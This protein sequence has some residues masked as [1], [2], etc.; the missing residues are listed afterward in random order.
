MGGFDHGG[1]VSFLFRDQDSWR[2][3]LIMTRSIEM[4]KKIMIVE[5]NVAA[6][7]MIRASLEAFGYNVLDLVMQGEEIVQQIEE[8]KPDLIIMDIVLQRGRMDG[9]TAAE[10][11]SES[12]DTPIVYITGNNTDALYARA[13]NTRPYGYILKPFKPAELRAAV[14]MALNKSEAESELKKH[15]DQLEELVSERTLEL[16][17]MNE[18]LKASLREKEILLKEIHHRVKNNMQLISSLLHIQAAHSED[19]K[20]LRFYEESRNRIRAMALVHESLYRSKSLAHIDICEHTRT[21]VSQL[22]RS[23]ECYDVE[24]SITGESIFLGIDVAI[25]F[26]LIVNE[27]VSNAFRHGLRGREKG[28]LGVEVHCSPE[29]VVTLIVSDNGCG[30]PEG[31]D[32][33]AS[34]S[35]GLQLVNDLVG[36]ID[37]SIELDGSNGTT[38]TVRFPVPGSISSR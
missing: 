35:L 12:F 37:G 5:D 17:S 9:I 33:R 2:R 26:G 1:G 30:F 11:I 34:S 14:E 18:Q 20:F 23:Y 8:K 15:R 24:L 4:S 19:P 10:K 29:R 13:R 3:A 28:A 7:A 32:F 22:V 27:L 31:L 38:F 25:P 6:A 16:T 21:L 36:Q